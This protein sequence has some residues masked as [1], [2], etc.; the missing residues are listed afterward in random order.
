MRRNLSASKNVTF[1]NRQKV[2]FALVER[3]ISHSVGD[4]VN[5]AS[6]YGTSVPFSLLTSW[7]ARQLNWTLIKVPNQQFSAWEMEFCRQNCHIIILCQIALTAT[8][9]FTTLQRK[10]SCISRTGEIYILKGVFL[11]FQLIL[12]ILLP[13]TLLFLSPTKLDSA[14]VT[15]GVCIKSSNINVLEMYTICN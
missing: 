8:H 3:F 13:S 9:D 14:H 1:G 11:P 10:A 5:V 6:I 12:G 15:V 2:L 4:G 7:S